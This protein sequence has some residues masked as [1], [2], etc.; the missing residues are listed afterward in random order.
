MSY[1]NHRPPTREKSR[2]P[3][4][5]PSLISY[6]TKEINLLGYLNQY[7]DVD[8]FRFNRAQYS[9]NNKIAKSTISDIISRLESDGLVHRPHYGNVTIT[10]KGQNVLNGQNMGGRISRG[11]GRTREVLSAH[12]Y[13]FICE[14]S[15]YNLKR[16]EGYPVHTVKLKNHIQHMIKLDDCTIRLTP[17]KAILVLPEVFNNDVDIADSIAFE[18]MVEVCGFLRKCDLSLTNVRLSSSHYARMHSYFAEVLQ[19]VDD[20]YKI[21]LDDGSY[22]WLDRSH[23]PQH[24]EDETDDASKRERMDN[25]IK[26]LFSTDAVLSDVSELKGVVQELVKLQVAQNKQVLTPKNEPI[27]GWYLG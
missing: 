19:S 14:H 8:G 18:R 27:E 1:N 6:G 9:R 2:N 7:K 10:Q 11:G 20:H 22:F 12:R 15:G 23:D 16:F 25:F 17:K 4:V 5:P 26:D 3:T 13:E 24:P 21:K